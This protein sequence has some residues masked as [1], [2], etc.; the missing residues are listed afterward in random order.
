M[1]VTQQ[2]AKYFQY[3]VMGHNYTDIVQVFMIG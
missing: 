1:K 2:C 3:F